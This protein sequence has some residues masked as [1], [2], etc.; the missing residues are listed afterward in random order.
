MKRTLAKREMRILAF[1][2]GAL[3]LVV[4]VLL[5][6]FARPDTR[7]RPFLY[8]PAAA[9]CPQTGLSIQT[10]ISY[11]QPDAVAV[12]YPVTGNAAVDRDI[13]ALVKEERNRYEAAGEGQD[14][15]GRELNLSYELTRFNS[16]L[17]SVC[18]SVVSDGPKD[19][20]LLTRTYDLNTGAS[21]ALRDFFLPE[22]DYLQRLSD[23]AIERLRQEYPSKASW[24]QEQWQQLAGPEKIDRF[25]L[26]GEVLRLYF[27]Q[28]DGEML[29]AKVPLRLLHSVSLFD[30]PDTSGLEKNGSK[31]PQLAPEQ[32]GLP[33]SPDAKKVALL[34]CDGPF[35]D[36][37][38]DILD[39]L[40]SHGARA[41]FCPLGNRAAYQ[42]ELVRRMVLEGHAVC[43]HTDSH[44]KL[45]NLSPGDVSAQLKKANAALSSITGVSPTLICP[46]YEAVG[47]KV[48]TLD[49]MQVILPDLQPADW[50]APDA[51]ALADEILASV[52]DGCVVQLHDR[53][54]VTA[55]AVQILLEELPAQG[56]AFVTV[57][58]LME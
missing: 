27:Q 21:L 54:P 23:Y 57:E 50:Q 13:A 49:G 19:H 58:E 12:S 48:K 3:L 16:S 31:N 52:Y 55:Q 46:P 7:E 6:V 10:E 20:R 11:G 29:K 14:P 53:F 47:A 34:F 9:S 41:T 44:K 35:E 1:G 24:S 4:A 15:S 45:E 18:F 33:A 2:G 26:D 28:E 17:V 32:E 25:V 36:T 56:Y 38:G 37:T 22:S 5:A 51:R 8:D 30:F 42:P 43:N 39:Q 40:K